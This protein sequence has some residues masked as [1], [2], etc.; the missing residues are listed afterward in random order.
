MNPPSVVDSILS[1]R[2]LRK[3][4]KNYEDICRRVASAL[5]DD[6]TEKARFYEAMVSLRFLPNSP[7]LMN[8]GTELGQ[9]SAC[10]TLPVPDSIDGIFDAMK[11]GAIIHKTGGGT[12][13]NFSHIRPEGS[14]VQSTDG[15]ASGPI[16]FMRVFNAATDVIKQ[17]GRRRGANMGILNVWHP[18]I[19]AFIAAKKK[20]GDF[21]NFNISVMVNDRFMDLVEK[22]RFDDVWLTNPHSGA[23]VTV[24]QIWTGIVEGIWKNGEPGILFYDEIN[25]HNPTPQ[26]GEIDTTNPCGEQPLLPYE[27]CVLG[28]INLAAC[29]RDGVLDEDLLRE[30]ARM[31]TRFLD[32]VIEKNVFPIPQIAEATRRTRKIGLGVMGVHDAMLMIGLAYDSAGGRAWSEQVMKLVTDTAID[33]SHKRAEKR[34]TFPAWQGS[35]W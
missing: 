33:E 25:R 7:T 4:E 30:T 26:L 14:P 19:L 15:V 12:G 35:I 3:G 6:E 5:A 31:A 32:L 34:G 16:S 27:S 17:G 10:F 8:A 22:R 23:K 21:S 11:E 1:A 18:D 2:Y 20:E 9:L 24:G 28:S 13:Y 29:V